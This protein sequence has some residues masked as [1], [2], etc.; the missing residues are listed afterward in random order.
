[1]RLFSADPCFKE[2]TMTFNVIIQ[3]TQDTAEGSLHWCETE[4]VEALDAEAARRLIVV[5][6]ECDQ[7]TR[8]DPA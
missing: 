4:T 2:G 8:V 7:I 3:H 1:M 5:D 6:G